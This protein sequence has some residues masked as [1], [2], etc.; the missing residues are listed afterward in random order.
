MKEYIVWEEACIFIGGES[1]DKKCSYNYDGEDVFV[2]YGTEAWYGSPWRTYFNREIIWLPRK[3]LNDIA[4]CAR[5]IWYCESEEIN[6]EWVDEG[7]KEEMIVLNEDMD[8]KEEV[9]QFLYNFTWMIHD[10]VKLVLEY[11]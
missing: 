11:I 9:Y 2:V 1:F 3:G 7:Y 8:M 4:L 5:E 6:G 10:D